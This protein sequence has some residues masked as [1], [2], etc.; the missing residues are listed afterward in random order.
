MSYR[1]KVISV[2]YARS[3][4]ATYSHQGDPWLLYWVEVISVSFARS[5]YGTLPELRSDTTIWS[6]K[7]L[8]S[9]VSAYTSHNTQPPG[10]AMVVLL[11]LSDLSELCYI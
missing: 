9:L 5:K 6:T 4:Y 11:V 7:V 10:G 1:F 3:K 2:S 8:Q